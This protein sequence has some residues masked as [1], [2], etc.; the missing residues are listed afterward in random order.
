MSVSSSPSRRTHKRAIVIGGSMSGLFSAAFLRQIGWD[1]D[2]YERSSVELVG[3]GAGITT[4]PELIEALEASG[5]G[6]ADLGVEVPK[7][8]ALDREGRV[9]DERPLRQV[10]TSWDRLQRLLRGTI[11]EAHYHLGHAFERVDQDERGVRVQFNK[12]RVEHADLLIGGDGIRSSVRAQLAP[13]LQPVYAGYYIWRGAPNEA[14]LS[15]KTLRD[16]FPYFTFYLPPRQE[17]ITYPIAGFDNELSP[18][19][20]R[21]NFIWYRVADAARLREMC[22]DENGVQHEH[23]VPPPLI[24][25]DL[26]AEMYADARDIMPEVMLDCVM[27]MHQPFI[28]PIYDFTADRIVFG[29][30]AMVGDAA[31]NAR[32]HMG[33]GVAKAG[34]DAMALA[35]HLR[36]NEDIDTAL[37]AYNTER[38]PVGNTIVMHSR[39]LGTHM[40]V[41]LKTEEDRRMHELLQSDGAMMDWIAVP[42]FLDAYK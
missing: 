39:K 17:V 34:G 4:H 35:K 10:L 2:V 36:D 33:F 40:G 6:T 12:G 13:E 11:D 25:K 41:D 15:P 18:G 22:V 20:R 30:T 8:I 16:I 14:D 37:K 21:Y 24:R 38:Q 9:T 26:V 28:T 29:R 5:A 1:V 31:A 3:R 32:P 7:R 23:S 42:N 27:T 19:K